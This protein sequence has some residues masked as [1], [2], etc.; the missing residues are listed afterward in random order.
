M[1]AEPVGAGSNNP[2]VHRDTHTCTHL[3]HMPNIWLNSME[4]CCFN[5]G[6]NRIE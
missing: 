5:L 3:L 4:I 2:M 6:K 1:D